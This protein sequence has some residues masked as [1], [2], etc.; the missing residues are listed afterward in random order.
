MELLII[1]LGLSATALLVQLKDLVETDL[2][3][4]L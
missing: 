3:T 1:T 2:G 4:A